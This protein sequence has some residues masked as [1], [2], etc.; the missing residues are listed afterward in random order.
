MVVSGRSKYLPC[1]EHIN[2]IDRAWHLHTLLAF[3]MSVFV[4]IQKSNRA[5]L[6]LSIFVSDELLKLSSWLSLVGELQFINLFGAGRDIN[7]GVFDF[8]FLNQSILNKDWLQGNY[9]RFRLHF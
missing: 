6:N 7:R 4:L 9:I 8:P 5:S 3:A 2:Y 1:V